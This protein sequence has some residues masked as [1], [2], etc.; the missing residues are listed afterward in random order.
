M[1][2]TNASPPPCPQCQRPLPSGLLAGFCPVCL[3]RQ[4]GE[5]GSSEREDRPAFVAPSLDEIARLFPNLEIQ[6]LLGAGGMGAVYRAR[7]PALDRWVAL[8]IL[9]AGGSRGPDF[10]E[11]FNREARALARLTHAHIVA[12]HE[13]GQVG[14][15]HYFLME[16]VDGTNLRQLSRTGRVSPREALQLIPQICDALQYAHDEGV[17]HRDIKPE[18]VLVDR[19]GRVKIAD[20][21]LAKI[22][23]QDPERHRLTLEGQVMGTPHYMAPEQLERPLTV[24]HRADIYSLGVV[25]Y[26]L[27]TGDLPLGK[28]LPP[29]RKVSVDGRLDEV[30][31]RALENDPERRYQQAHEVKTGVATAIGSPEDGSLRGIRS[32]PAS[33]DAGR[34]S[35]PGVRYGRWA[36]IPAVVERDG[37]REVNFQGA[38]GVFF[39]MLMTAALAEQ[40]VRWRSGT[41]HSMVALGFVTATLAGIWAIRRTMNQPWSEVSPRMRRLGYLRDLLLVVGLFAF[42]VGI[43]E[44]KV[45]AIRPEVAGAQTMPLMTQS[46]TLMARFPDGGSV[47]LL[48]IADPDSATNG[49]WRADGT[50]QTEFT[51][52]VPG[53]GPMPP[54]P[55]TV[56]MVDGKEVPASDARLKNF[57]L[58]WNGM[59][60][61][62]ASQVEFESS[63]ASGGVSGAGE[64]LF[65][66]QPVVSD[67]R[68]YLVSYPAGR[69][70]A[71]IRL[72]A[73]SG[74]WQTVASMKGPTWRESP[75]G[76]ILNGNHRMRFFGLPATSERGLQVSYLQ[77]PADPGRSHRLVAVDFRGTEH[78][79]RG[80]GSGSGPDQVY[81]MHFDDLSLAD[82]MELRLQWRPMNWVTF[83]DVALEPS[84][85]LPRRDPRRQSEA[86][87]KAPE[88]PMPPEPAEEGPIHVEGLGRFSVL[89]TALDAAPD[90]ATI[91]LDAGT[92]PVQA[93][94]RKQV[95]LRGDSWERTV[96][97]PAEAWREPSAGEIQAFE[98]SLRDAPSAAAREALLAGNNPMMVRPIVRIEGGGAA[99]IENIQFRME[100]LPPEG[101]KLRGGMIEVSASGRLPTANLLLDECALV[102]SPGN[103]VV[104][105]AGARVAIQRCLIS[106]AWNRGIFCDSASAAAV[107]ESDIRNCHY[108]GI[109][110]GP[111]ASLTVTRSRISGA[112]W[113]GIRYDDTSPE[114][115]GC[116]IF[117]NARSGI[118][119][120]GETRATVHG[121]VF[122]GNEMSGMSCWFRN[123]DVIMGNTFYGN[124]REGLSILGGSSPVVTSNVF[125]KHRVAV[126]QGLIGDEGTGASIGTPRLSFNLS[127]D[128]A[129]DWSGISAP[130]ESGSTPAPVGAF[131]LRDNPGLTAPEAH[132]FALLPG[133][134]ARVAGVGALTPL[135][136]FSPF[137]LQP[138]V[139]AM[140]PEGPTRDSRQWKRVPRP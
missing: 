138:T 36:G 17:V 70:T 61:G 64:V 59:R 93:V 134:P 133:S 97:V 135:P 18:N 52:D 11:R 125:Q 68:R 8:K 75:P 90:N 100:G 26:E 121:N 88:P 24:D 94:I 57:V 126:V 78:R 25:F 95:V 23:G 27:L 29:S 91:H 96:L 6:G 63:L 81:V 108:A 139:S 128:N 9:P 82:V 115:T 129:S 60:P 39:V 112:A 117:G 122:F 87:Q 31:L 21:G 35:K 48:G 140:I 99:A 130:G 72:G 38:L 98:Q 111:G 74:D 109:T 15:L 120:S 124:L 73:E 46:G 106:G 50:A 5:T 80:S 113:H 3:L 127:W 101:M 37:E 107:V 123:A 62:A 1:E 4:G 84:R 13:F 86:I 44:L 56:S 92:Y 136:Y 69:R 137:P 55:G 102:G 34:T 30:V 45:R 89:Q 16:F 132:D 32:N 105:L 42:V 33:T 103:G 71:T 2:S 114:I 22:M 40:S 41:E 20:F 12:V 65:N 83:S 118:Y 116:L 79:A 47:Q 51:L 58:Q 14:E 66:G 7:Q 54:P 19:R 53:D 49:W 119:A 76:G 77:G 10:A 43:H 110:A 28:F 131:P 85:P 104:A 67:V